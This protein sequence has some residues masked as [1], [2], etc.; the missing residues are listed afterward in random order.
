[1]GPN[2]TWSRLGD[3]L[4]QW[5][6]Q[7]LT[8]TFWWRDDDATH[9]TPQL[10]ALFNCAGNTPIA[11]AVIPGK[12]SAELATAVL[13]RP[14]VWVLQHGW[15]HESHAPDRQS[16]YPAERDPATVA[17]E[18][19]CGRA[20]LVELFGARAL[21]VFVPPYHDFEK[22]F[23]PLLPENG[24]KMISGKG[25]RQSRL[26][27]VDLGQSNA[28]VAPIEWTTPASFGSEEKYL[29]EVTKILISRRLEKCDRLEPTGII[30][31][32]L[33]QPA[34]SLDFIRRLIDFS[35]VVAN[36]IWLDPPTVFRRTDDSAVV[37]LE[38]VHA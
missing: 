3:E 26:A 19:S 7:S 25:L 33:H 22:S 15:R 8:P 24:I 37:A 4:N 18:I 31:H 35:S 10:D 6:R 30:T 21:P 14:T 17:S 20:R 1:M 12:A 29:N 16:E 23:L 9:C 27:A 38:Q 32:H 34:E 13:Q 36:A 5:V 2:R 28:H 11:L